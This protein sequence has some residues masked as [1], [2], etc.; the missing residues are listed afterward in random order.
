MTV[1]EAVAGGW[2]GWVALHLSIGIVGTW[3]ARRYALHRQLVDQ[4]GERRSHDTPT[5]RGGGISIV[6]SM[7]VALCGLAWCFPGHATLML[8]TAAGTALVAGIGWVDDH[9]PLPPWPRLLVQA[10]AAL[11]LAWG[12]QLEGAGIAVAGA[13]FVAALVLVNV[14]NFMDGID[15]LAASQALLVATAYGLWAGVGVGAWFALALAA[16]CLG[17]LPFNLPRARIFLGD[18]GSGALGYGLAALAAWLLVDAGPRGPLLLLPL[19]A[20][21]IDATL[22]LALRVLGGE[23]WWMPHA[24]HAYQYWVRRCGRHGRVTW[25]YAAWTLLACLAM[26]AGRGAPPAFIMVGLP[27]A[28][29]LGAGVWAYLRRTVRRAGEDA[30]E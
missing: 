29:L 30:R 18:V 10:V 24:G 23:R 25:S 3:L 5:P 9:H 15:A 19:S 16:A 4:P 20:F 1:V 2:V 28:G 22:T 13:G 21:L 26:L 11:L 6:A 27:V 12:L 14:W 8:A 7:L 17:F